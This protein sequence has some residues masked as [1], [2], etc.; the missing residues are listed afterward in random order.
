[1]RVL[2]QAISQSR[3]LKLTPTCADAAPGAS[4]ESINSAVG[5]EC[6]I[7][8]AVHELQM[9]SSQHYAKMVSRETISVVFSPQPKP[10]RKKNL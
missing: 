5:M 1:V 8:M 3:W 2:S 10:H 4:E 9:M 6:L 7:V